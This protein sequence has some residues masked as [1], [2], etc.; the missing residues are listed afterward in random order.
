MKLDNICDWITICLVVNCMV[1]FN[2]ITMMDIHLFFRLKTN[3]QKRYT[4][5]FQK[6]ILKF[7]H[8]FKQ[9][10]MY[11]SQKFPRSVSLILIEIKL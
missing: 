1:N 2:L 4:R 7:I 5:S 10:K 9:T 8:L 11:N 6:N 3:N